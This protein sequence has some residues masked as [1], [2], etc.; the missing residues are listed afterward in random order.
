MVVILNMSDGSQL[1]HAK[2]H[3]PVIHLQIHGANLYIG[4]ALGD[5]WTMDLTYFSISY[6]NLLKQVWKEVPITWENGLPILRGEPVNHPCY[7]Q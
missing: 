2:L 6:C 3:G 7:K 1:A 4:T 5:Y